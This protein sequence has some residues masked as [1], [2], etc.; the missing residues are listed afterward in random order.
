MK[1]Y[2]LWI[3]ICAFS[4]GLLL[5][6][7]YPASVPRAMGEDGKIPVVYVQIKAGISPAQVDLVDQAIASAV[8]KGAG[9]LLIRL[10]TPGGLVESMRQ[11]VQS[12]LNSPV[13]VAV[14]VGPSGARA[15]SAGVF[16]VAAADIAAMSPQST[17]GAASP[18]M[19]G[20]KDMDSTMAHKVK[21]DLL[22][23]V[24]S[25]A[26]SHG[27]NVEWYEQSVD[28]AVSITAEEAVMQRVVEYIAPDVNDL[29]VQIGAQGGTQKGVLLA[30]DGDGYRIVPFEPGM[31]YKLLSWLIDPQ[32]AYFLLLGGMAGLFFELTTPG[33]ILPGVIGGICL[34]LGLYAMS[35]LP[36]SVTGLLLILFGLVLFLLEIKVVSYGMLSIAAIVSLFMGSLILFKDQSGVQTLP[37]STIIATVLGV[38]LL[39][40]AAVYLAAKA[41][42]APRYSGNS[43]MVG[44]TGVIK[45][46]EQG[47]GKL[48][49]RG[50]LWNFTLVEGLNA[51]VGDEVQI[52]EVNGLQLVADK[53]EVKS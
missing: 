52:V 36:T 42:L 25:V 13:P 38:S 17:I 51:A 4:L 15:A 16:I 33:A 10:D 30:F 34:L 46:L 43:A 53:A 7:T 50:E 8:E 32:I 31:R 24:R 3:S 5:T 49:V 22:S 47:K 6:T 20:G 14:W 9:M 19:A 29:L 37:L 40:L 45:S 2:L 35:V 27:R 11:I 41:Q 21:N 28:K 48:L 23:L 39:C 12:I 1:K 44:L 18:V 26:K